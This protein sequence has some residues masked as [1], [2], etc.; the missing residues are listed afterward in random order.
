MSVMITSLLTVGIL[1]AIVGLCGL[2]TWVEKKYP[3][4]EYDERQQIVHGRAYRLSFL[5]GMVY[6]IPVTIWQMFQAE[7][8]KSSMDMYVVIF[9]GLWIQVLLFAT[10]CIWN[11]AALPLSEK[12]PWA[13]GTC[14][15]I[16]GY[17]FLKFFVF[18]GELNPAGLKFLPLFMGIGFSYIALLYLIQ[19]LQWK[20]E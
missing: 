14:L 5:A 12:H 20:K 19:Y 16:A 1:L 13:I 17:Y 10:Y 3:G 7:A 11:G 6:F 18:G 2:T 9:L 15:F 8:G 4:K